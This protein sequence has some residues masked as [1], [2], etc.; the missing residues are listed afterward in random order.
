MLDRRI[1]RN[2]RNA[3]GQD[4]AK[5]RV[6][7]R[8]RIAAFNSRV[9]NR[10][11]AR[12]SDF[13]IRCGQLLECLL[14][15]ASH[16]TSCHSPYSVLP[17]EALGFPLAKTNDTIESA[18]PP[19]RRQFRLTR[20]TETKDRIPWIEA[21]GT[22][23]SCPRFLVSPAPLYRGLHRKCLLRYTRLINSSLLA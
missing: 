3:F 22:I 1:L 2:S 6:V 9:Q 13:K 4:N 23:A 11:S 17:R 16:R 18:N 14:H 5:I 19:L 21:F 12:S 10:L 20:R 7:I 8:Q 15:R